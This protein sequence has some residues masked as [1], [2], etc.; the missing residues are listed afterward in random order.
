MAVREYIGARYVPI[1][2]R[3]GEESIEWDNTKPYEPLTIVL[4]DGNSYTSRQ[5]VPVGIDIDNEEY[6]ALTGNY[7]AQVELYR[8]ETQDAADAAANASNAAN[9][10]LGMIGEGF[11]SEATVADAMGHA[12]DEI[13]DIQGFLGDT[14]HPYDLVSITPIQDDEYN[15]TGFVCTIPREYYK[16]E[17]CAGNG[18]QSNVISTDIVNGYAIELLDED[19]LPNWAA[20]FNCALDGV[21][22]INGSKAIEQPSSSVGTT[23]CIVYFNTDGEM[24]Y[25]YEQKTATELAADPYF[26]YNAF[27][28]YFPVCWGESVVTPDPDSA[29]PDATQG[30]L[31]YGQRLVIGCDMNYWYVFEF[32]ARCAG[33]PDCAL[34]NVVDYLTANYLSVNTVVCD[35]G[36]SVQFYIAS[37]KENIFFIGDEKKYRYARDRMHFMGFSKKAGIE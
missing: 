26:A 15:L 33:Q 17:F 35:G 9:S 30:F 20:V 4:N 6:W 19:K 18:K 5:Y 16:L 12:Y 31:H 3:V 24:G 28:A 25:T 10:A 34:K 11:T 36:G 14:F 2:G 8:R 37:S 7:N 27:Q 29:Y 1:F 21:K 13:S 32:A 23:Q 22:I